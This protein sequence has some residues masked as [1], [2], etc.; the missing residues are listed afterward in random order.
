MAGDWPGDFVKESLI[1]AALYS[2]LK[3]PQGCD[4]SRCQTRQAL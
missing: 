3:P 1:V 2:N 4:L